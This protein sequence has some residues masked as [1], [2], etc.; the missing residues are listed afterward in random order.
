MLQLSGKES[1]ALFSFF[2]RPKSYQTVF[3]SPLEY[4]TSSEQKN[5]GPLCFFGF[6]S[7]SS[8]LTGGISS[9]EHLLAPPARLD[10]SDYDFSIRFGESPGGHVVVPVGGA[11]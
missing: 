5:S 2:S 11:Y 8:G 6:F 9:V 1:F 3:T 10:S 4:F 7:P